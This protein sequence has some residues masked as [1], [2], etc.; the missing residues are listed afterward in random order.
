MI[1]PVSPQPLALITHGH[2]DHARAGHDHVIAT[3]Q[4]LDIMASR[5]GRRILRNL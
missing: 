2:A 3:P 5:Y 4:T 1:D